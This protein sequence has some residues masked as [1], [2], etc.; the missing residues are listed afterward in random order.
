M[1]LH[2]AKQRKKT[3]LPSILHGCDPQKANINPPKRM[4]HRS[5]SK[6]VQA[7]S[8]ESIKQSIKDILQDQLILRELIRVLDLLDG[9]RLCGMLRFALFERGFTWGK[10]EPAPAQKPKNSTTSH[11]LGWWDTT[12]EENIAAIKAFCPLFHAIMVHGNTTG[13]PIHK[14]T[15]ECMEC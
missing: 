3:S 1:Y 12:L 14:M 15:M 10:R 13:F 5:A 11:V 7:W 6:A 4:L 9:F 8:D 2:K